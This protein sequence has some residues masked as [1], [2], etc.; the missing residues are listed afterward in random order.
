MGFLILGT[1]R[2]PGWILV[3]LCGSLDSY[4]PLLMLM[5]ASLGG[6]GDSCDPL[7]LILVPSLV[8]S[9]SPFVALVTLVTLH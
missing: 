7:L 8:G 2:L 5:G 1:L 9:S 3:T 4:D 6:P